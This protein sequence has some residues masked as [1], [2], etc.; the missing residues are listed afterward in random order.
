MKHI[1]VVAAHPDDEVLGCGGTIAR[2]IKDGDNVSVVFMA[3]GVTSRDS[4]IVKESVQERNSSAVDACNKLGIKNTYFLG[5]PDNRMDSIALLDVVKEIEKIITEIVPHTIYTHHYGDLNIDHQVTHQAVM[6]A[7]R[8]EPSCCVKEIYTFEVLS[9]TEWASPNIDN[10]FIP[11]MFVDIT[12]TL[13]QKMAALECY[14]EE[15]RHFPHS[16]SI[17]SVEALAKFRGASIGKSA[18]EA[19]AVLRVIK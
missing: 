17:E 1:L 3:D 19:F 14:H 9:S 6:T 18:A 4:A 2:H 12:D 8:P 5:F 13:E 11:N 15:M 7:C 10:A 16:R